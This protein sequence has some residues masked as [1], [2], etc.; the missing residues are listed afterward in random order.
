LVVEAIGSRAEAFSPASTP[1]LLR[2]VSAHARAATSCAWATSA[3][4]A[5]KTVSAA[6]S[7]AMFEVLI[8]GP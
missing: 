6:T 2:S 1:P 4:H 3:V 8:T 5:I 7:F